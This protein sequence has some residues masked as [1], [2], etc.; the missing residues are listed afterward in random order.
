MLRLKYSKELM[1]VG[2]SSFSTAS[3]AANI[4]AIIG[5]ALASIAFE[6]MKNHDSSTE[7]DAVWSATM[8]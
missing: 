3:I 8:F 7:P 4:V 2:T 1:M 5:P 6:M